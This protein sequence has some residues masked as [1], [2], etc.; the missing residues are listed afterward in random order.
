MSH[1]GDDAIAVDELANLRQ[2]N[3]A[4]G[5]FDHEHRVYTLPMP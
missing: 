4:A 3:E 1:V 2:R 5:G